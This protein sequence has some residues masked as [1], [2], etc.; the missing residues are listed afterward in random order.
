VKKLATYKSL[1]RWDNSLT[2]YMTRNKFTM[3]IKYNIHAH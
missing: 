1:T 2:V 3:I